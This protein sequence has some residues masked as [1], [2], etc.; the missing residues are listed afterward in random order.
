MCA[1]WILSLWLWS[2]PTRQIDHGWDARKTFSA[3]VVQTDRHSITISN[4][5]TPASFS[6][7]NACSA[8]STT[9][10]P[11]IIIIIILCCTRCAAVQS[12]I[13]HLVPYKFSL[14]SFVFVF[15]WKL[16]CLYSPQPF[17]AIIFVHTLESLLPY[18]PWIS[19]FFWWVHRQSI[20]TVIQLCFKCCT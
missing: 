6:A 17:L 19:F 3:N 7:S 9:T 16:L 15:H 4:T 1:R 5:I 8:V 14:L 2:S 20:C 18:Y 12:M 10:N 11:F 13:M